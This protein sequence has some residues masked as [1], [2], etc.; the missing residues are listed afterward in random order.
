[1]T[2]APAELVSLTATAHDAQSAVAAAATEAAATAA[3]QNATATAGGV[4][5][6]HV[7]A[8]AQ[9][10]DATVTVSN[11]VVSAYAAPATVAAAA[12]QPLDVL[13]GAWGYGPRP[14]K[15]V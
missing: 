6:Q 15:S 12:R 4:G 13:I 7:F 5:I 10:L 14:A 11:P 2:S 9:A 1:M 8:L 3:A